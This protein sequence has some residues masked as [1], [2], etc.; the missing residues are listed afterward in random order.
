MTLCCISTLTTAISLRILPRRYVKGLCANQA[1]AL[2]FRLSI[3]NSRAF[4]RA[5]K[6]LAM[7]ALY[8]ISAS[9]A[10]TLRLVWFRIAS[11]FPIGNLASLFPLKFGVLTATQHIERLGQLGLGS[12]NYCCLVTLISQPSLDFN[13]IGVI[14]QKIWCIRM[15]ATIRQIYGKYVRFIKERALQVLQITSIIGFPSGAVICLQIMAPSTNAKG[16]I[17]AH[18]SWTCLSDLR[19]NK[20]LATTV[21]ARRKASRNCKWLLAIGAL[22]R[23]WSFS[24]P[25][26]CQH[27]ISALA[28]CL[29]AA[30]LAK[31]ILACKS[32]ISKHFNAARFTRISPKFPGIFATVLIRTVSPA[33]LSRFSAVKGLAAVNTVITHNA[34]IVSQV[35]INCN[36]SRKGG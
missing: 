2:L 28:N 27:I 20:A 33:K 8:R 35:C 4:T 6:C 11:I 1:L 3:T 17:F 30:G 15:A 22:K 12:S 5:K 10:S 24:F 13:I 18:T 36:S 9:R 7:N 16:I 14:N 21:L 31:P 32:S 29:G 34:G 19:K 26:A 25:L 23:N